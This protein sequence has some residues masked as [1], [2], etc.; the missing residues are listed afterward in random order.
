M[1]A[2]R[3]GPAPP[4]LKD[5]KATAAPST[6]PQPE[7]KAVEQPKPATTPPRETPPAQRQ[8]APVEAAPKPVDEKK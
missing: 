2:P 6:P 3:H 7:A 8:A 4:V 5:D 1:L